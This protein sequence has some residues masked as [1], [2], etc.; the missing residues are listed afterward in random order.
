MCFYRPHEVAVDYHLV[1]VGEANEKIIS[2]LE[3][4]DVI[5]WNESKP[6]VKIA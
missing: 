5:K 1:W 3:A 6:H 2:W 4:L